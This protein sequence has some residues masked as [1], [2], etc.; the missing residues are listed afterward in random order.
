MEFSALGSVPPLD[1]VMEPRVWYAETS[2]AW[3]PPTLQPNPANAAH[4]TPNLGVPALH[5]CIYISLSDSGE[6][7]QKP[8][9]PFLP[10]I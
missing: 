8:T 4:P 9:G 2:A 5:V 10:K 1:I 3:Q 6:N 7:R